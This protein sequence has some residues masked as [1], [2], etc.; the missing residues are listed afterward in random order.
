MLRHLV[1]VAT[2]TALTACGAT[3][4]SSAGSG[5]SRYGPLNDANRVGLVKYSID[6][7]NFMISRRRNDAYKKMYESCGGPYVI[8]AES[9]RDENGKMVSTVTDSTSGMTTQ[10]STTREAPRGSRTVT[11]SADTSQTS[12]Q[13]TVQSVQENVVEHYWYVQYRCATAADT[14]KSP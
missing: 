3:R 8:V 14:L 5:G 12:G 9:A 4:I 1:I 7:A 6:G 13:R 11:Q 10:S 2:A